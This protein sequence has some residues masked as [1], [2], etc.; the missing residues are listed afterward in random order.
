MGAAKITA[1]AKIKTLLNMAPTPVIHLI[2][3]LLAL[4]SHVKRTMTGIR[5][6]AKS[7]KIDVSFA[8]FST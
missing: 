4:A 5:Y 6:G 7:D 2:S 3:Y 8:A 1:A